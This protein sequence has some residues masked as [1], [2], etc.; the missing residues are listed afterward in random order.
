MK[1]VL[2]YSKARNDID[3]VKWKKI[4]LC[5]LT[6]CLLPQNVYFINKIK[7]C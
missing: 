1:F 5:L 3:T 2:E 7:V 6:A 4:Q